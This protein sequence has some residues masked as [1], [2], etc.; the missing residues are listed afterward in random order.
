MRSSRTRNLWAASATVALVAVLSACGGG[1]GSNSGG[2]AGGGTGSGSATTQTDADGFAI[3]TGKAEKGGTVD[4]LG[5]VDFSHLD[6]AMGNDGNVN[7]FYR[8][9]YRTLTTYANEPGDGGTKVVPDLATD[10]GTPNA[11]ATVWTYKLKD[12]I[13]FQDGSPIT[14]RDV[15]FG[16]ERAQDPALAIGSND[17]R[18]YIKGADKYGGIFKQPEGLTSIETPDDKTIIF[19]LNQPLAGFPN[20]ATNGPL[21]PF[22]ASKVTSA[23]QI[24]TT[25]IA[26]GPYM[27]SSYERGSKLTLVRNPKW[28]ADSDTVRPAN[29]DQ[30]RFFFGI[31]SNTID[32]RLISGQGDDKNAVAASTNTLS[33]ASL[34]RIQAPQLK[35]RVVRDIPACTIF[36]GLN[37][38]KKPLNDLKVRQAISYAIDKQ[39]VITASGGPLLATVA[40]DMLTPKVPGRE[41]FD[42][43]P[44]TDHTGDVTK[45]KQLLTEAGYPN[46]FELTMDA[47]SIPKWKSW[48][49]AVQASLKKI[50]INVKLNVIDASTYYEVIG[51]P[52]KQHEMAITG[53]CSPWLSGTSLLIPL[54][55]G[56][57]IVPKGN[58]NIAQLDDPTINKRFDQIGQI[59]ELDKQNAEFGK[60]DK[61]IL[62]FAPVVPILRETPLQMV[63]SNVADAFAHAGETGYVDY[64]SLGLKNPK[65]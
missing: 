6:P 53:W 48:A 30:Y 59:S 16:F 21:V 58:Y 28:T 10:I 15:K 32:Q 47:R 33:A 4:V 55:K 49:V 31:D 43:Y 14:S 45:A 63:G 61:E 25:P 56:D 27:I 39:S 52:A 5:N 57:Q 64:T 1:S 3:R 26:S 54:F 50:N 38:T 9:I 29:P 12:N 13:F 46:G 40:T 37:M 11:D 22:P 19:H 23:K 20:I 42:L 24:D 8:L 41:D 34:G 18:T 17:G 7:N 2:S 51:T 44:S 65:G 36:L 62:Q 60:L 35:S